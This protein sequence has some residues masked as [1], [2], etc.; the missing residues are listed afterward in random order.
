MMK[1]FIGGYTSHTQELFAEQEV[2]SELELR[3]QQANFKARRLEQQANIEIQRLVQ[4]ANIEEQRFAQQADFDARQRG[5]NQKHIINIQEHEHL[6]DERISKTVSDFRSDKFTENYNFI[7]DNVS[8]YVQDMHIKNLNVNNQTSAGT[9]LYNLIEKYN[10]EIYS[11]T[12]DVNKVTRILALQQRLLTALHIY[13]N[14]INNN[15]EAMDLAMEYYKKLKQKID[16]KQSTKLFQSDRHK[17]K[18]QVFTTAL[19][20]VNNFVK[21]I[22]MYHADTTNNSEL[23]KAVAQQME[24]ALFNFEKQEI[25]IKNEEERHQYLDNLIQQSTSVYGQLKHLKTQ[26]SKAGDKTRDTSESL[27]STINELTGRLKDPTTGVNYTERLQKEL[28]E[29]QDEKATFVAE[30]EQKQLEFNT[31]QKQIRETKTEREQL[32]KTVTSLNKELEQTQNRGQRV[33]Q[34]LLEMQKQLQNDIQRSNTNEEENIEKLRTDLNNI[35]KEILES[36]SIDDN[37]KLVLHKII[38]MLPPKQLAS[39]YQDTQFTSTGSRMQSQYVNDIIAKHLF[40][41]SL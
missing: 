40:I 3:K 16:N 38:S 32:Q 30:Q 31:L 41:L 9:Y 34:E 39:N 7:R 24:K 6:N 23:I 27:D 13:T 25:I 21:K 2:T 22:C 1:Y 28:K 4:Q 35:M 37:T 19:D 26:T 14:S 36:T 5:N 29:M 18:M 15:D 20:N 8:K 10:T 12:T 33:I 11:N 17:D